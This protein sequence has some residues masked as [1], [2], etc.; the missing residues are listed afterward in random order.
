MES[1]PGG[2]L[3]S[4]GARPS[5]GNRVSSI[6]TQ[7]PTST[8]HSQGR[9][10]LR[11]PRR[12]L[13]ATNRASVTGT[14]SLCESAHPIKTPPAKARTVTRTVATVVGNPWPGLLDLAGC[15]FRHYPKAP[16]ACLELLHRRLQISAGEVWPHLGDKQELRIGTLPEKEIT[17]TLLPAAANH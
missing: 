6:G 16:I 8:A 12:K 14:S 11:H 15:H 4:R 3:G 7:I 17:Q 10:G 13:K 2:E 5:G 1:K 9:H